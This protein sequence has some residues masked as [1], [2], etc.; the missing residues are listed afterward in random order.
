[1]N[2]E[3]P[4]LELSEEARRALKQAAEWRL[5]SLLLERPRSGWHEEVRSLAKEVE[6]PQL[7][8]V[9]I[10]AVN[11]TE[12][13]Y[14]A[15]LGPA[16]FVSPREVA[17]AVFEDP[18]RML[19][20]LAAFYLAFAFSPRC[21]DPEDHIAVQTGFVG[22]LSLKDAY[23]QA[24]DNSDAVEATRAALSHFMEAHYA[25]LVHGF[26]SKLGSNGPAYLCRTVRILAARVPH[27]ETKESPLGVDLDPLT[28]GCP[29]ACEEQEE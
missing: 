6:D 21:E 20:D 8:E 3:S 22:Y 16:G 9:S 14:L 24:S 19:A 1:M 17:Y 27:V 2:M 26:A 7:R 13:A 5:L 12:E 29:M 23:A 28:G 11:A 15:V 10:D 18:G 25:R 4:V